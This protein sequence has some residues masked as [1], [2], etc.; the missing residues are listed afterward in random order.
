MFIELIG[1]HCA[2][3]NW[4]FNSMQMERK[5]SDEVFKQC[6]HAE[7]VIQL[8]LAVKIRPVGRYHDSTRHDLG[9]RINSAP[10]R[11]WNA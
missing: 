10:N 9:T 6:R 3:R 2:G 7:D 4:I 8:N 5:E 11:R 1:V